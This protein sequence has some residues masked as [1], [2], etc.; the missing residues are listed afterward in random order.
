[1]RMSHQTAFRIAVVVVAITAFLAAPGFPS[2]RVFEAKPTASPRPGNNHARTIPVSDQLITAKIT[3]DDDEH[4]V[5]ASQFEG[6]LIRIEKIGRA[7]YGFSPFISDPSNEI[8]TIK[9]YRISVSEK[10]GVVGEALSEVHALVADK[11]GKYFTTYADADARFKIEILGVQTDSRSRRAS[12]NEP[13]L[14]SECCVGC[15]GD[16]S[17]A[18]RVSTACGGCC[19]GGCCH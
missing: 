16:K 2:G 9:V 18:C 12:P 13:Y 1:M 19:S 7:V 4:V 17:C 11:A 15:E 6:G 8:I 10:D 3:I 5:E 14:L